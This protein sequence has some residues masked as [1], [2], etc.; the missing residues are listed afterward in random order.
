MS[1]G[2]LIRSPGMLP[3]VGNITVP[4]SS[5]NPIREG[6]APKS[7]G[8]PPRYE[9]EST[10]LLRQHHVA[11][12]RRGA[13]WLTLHGSVL[14]PP[15]QGLARKCTLGGPR[16]AKNSLGDVRG[17]VIRAGSSSLRA[18]RP[19]SWGPL[20]LGPWVHRSAHDT[21]S[22]ERDPTGGH[23]TDRYSRGHMKSDGV[24]EV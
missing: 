3:A 14:M 12:S 11:S 17:C 5:T 8:I 21:L 6:T 13:T 16:S 2:S 19:D 18:S 10:I 23:L 22:L 24:R 4:G 20:I 7:V 1:R 9:V 15:R